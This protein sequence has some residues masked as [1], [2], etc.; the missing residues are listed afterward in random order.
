MTLVVARQSGNT[1]V[2]VSDTG[3]TNLGERVSRDKFIPKITIIHPDIAVG[4]A[5]DPDLGLRAITTAPSERS[6][7]SMVDHFLSES[8]R[9]QGGVDFILTFNKPLVKSVVVS[10]GQVSKNRQWIGDHKA[11]SAFQKFFMKREVSPSASNLESLI[12]AT[13]LKLDSL[14]DNPTL[15][16][17]AAM[18]YVLLDKDVGSVFGDPLAVNNAEGSFLY[19]PFAWILGNIEQGLCR[20]RPPEGYEGELRE[21]SEFAYSCCV[22]KRPAP[23]RGVAYHYHFARLTYLYWGEIGRPIMNAEVIKDLSFEKFMKA[24]EER[25]EFEVKWQGLLA[26][27]ADSYPFDLD[28]ELPARVGTIGVEGIRVYDFAKDDE[29]YVGLRQVSGPPDPRATGGQLLAKTKLA[30]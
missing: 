22:I 26:P 12:V 6:Y 15:R 10:D 28:D 16:M 29:G 8:K 3:I 17:I 24:F 5:G 11:F 23:I 9:Y 7:R 13:S 4:F 20:I 27:I 2:L 21:L 30:N 19:R 18:R 25:F 1:I 14:D